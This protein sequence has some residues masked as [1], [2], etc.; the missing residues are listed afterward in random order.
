M[1]ERDE[2]GKLTGKY[3]KVDSDAYRQLSD[4]QKTYYNG[5]MEIKRELD[6]LLPFGLQE[7][8]N[9]PKIR[10]DFLEQLKRRDKAAY[11]TIKDYMSELWSVKSDDEYVLQNDKMLV[12]YNNK[13][14]KVVPVR[15]LQF[16][17]NEDS[18]P[19]DGYHLYYEHLCEDVLQLLYHDSCR[20]SS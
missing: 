8:L 5:I 6:S 10:K 16:A 13:Q 11:K 1:F 14:V 12:D 15:F 3:I 7:L 9:A 4:A 2:E 18:E 19:L 20:T 17:E